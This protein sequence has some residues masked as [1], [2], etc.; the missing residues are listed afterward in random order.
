MTEHKIAVALKAVLVYNRRILMLQRSFED[1]V[2][3]GIWEFPGGKLEFGET[4]RDGL[5]REIR[6][7]TGLAARVG[8]LLYATSF[9]TGPQRQVVLL[10]YLCGCESGAVRLSQEHEAFLWAARPQLAERLDPAILAD[11]KENRV[12]ELPELA[13]L[14]SS[15]VTGA[16]IS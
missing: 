4:L 6:E 12:L 10:T 5:K 8:Q 13:D 14:E 1:D 3:P 7:E 2:G 16:I 9:Q 11:L 15:L